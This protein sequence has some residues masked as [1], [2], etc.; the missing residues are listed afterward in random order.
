MPPFADCRKAA[1]NAQFAHGGEIT[2]PAHVLPL[3]CAEGL[4]DGPC[5]EP[6]NGKCNPPS[7]LNLAPQHNMEETHCTYRSWS[8]AGTR[9]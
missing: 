3:H 6:G 9:C 5:A 8:P 4:G 2:A 7:R 1:T